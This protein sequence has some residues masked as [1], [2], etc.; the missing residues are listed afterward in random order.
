MPNKLVNY[1]VTDNGIAIIELCSDSDGNPLTE[2][3][4]SVNTYTRSMWED[5]D[6]AILNAR[7]DDDVTV[8]MMI[9]HGE[10]FFSAGASI[11]Y[12]NT[13]TPRY[14]YF[15]CLH[16]NETL[17]RLEQTPKLVIA[18]LNG[19]AI[20]GGLEI[21]MAADIRIG[22]KDNGSVGLPEVSLGVLAGTGGTARL[23]R[24]VGKAKAMEIM[25]TGRKFSF[26]EAQE[27]DLV[28]DVYDS[29]NNEEFRSDV[30]DYASQ[31]TLPYA[32]AKAIGNIK[33]SV[34]SGMEIPLEYHLALERELQSDL[35]Q[36]NDA[37][38]GIAAYVEKKTPRFE[39]A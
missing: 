35:F 8:I 17:S 7:F 20:G 22:L 14:K 19:H 24:L 26:E 29:T 32:A 16:A 25:V 34:Q 21:A 31:F 10:K 2:G 30:M 1:G 28:H 33:R 23:S 27:M 15:F 36:S 18:A 6:Q 13:L 37:K 9:G 11:N 39:G 38:T 12:L 5:I 4:T 3:K